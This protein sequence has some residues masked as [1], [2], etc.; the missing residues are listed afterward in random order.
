METLIVVGIMLAFIGSIIGLLFAI[1]G[2][3]SKNICQC[4]YDSEG[5]MVWQT[6][7]CPVHKRKVVSEKKV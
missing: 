2:P 1:F 6:Y 5:K 7:N 4:Y 3:P